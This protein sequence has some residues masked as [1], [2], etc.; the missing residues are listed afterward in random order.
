M[1]RH[2][3]HPN[4]HLMFMSGAVVKGGP[5]HRLTRNQQT[6]LLFIVAVLVMCA[7]LALI[8]FVPLPAKAATAEHY[9]VAYVDVNAGSSLNVRTGPGGDWAY[10][11]LP[12]RMDVVILQTADGWAEVNTPERIQDGLGPMGWVSMDYLHTYRDYIV[13][14]D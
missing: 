2:L 6:D 11:G 13:L 14:E 3:T 1:K 7:L 4:A 12:A 5:R 8:A 10:Y 9:Q